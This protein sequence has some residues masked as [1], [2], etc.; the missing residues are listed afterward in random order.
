[1]ALV[2]APSGIAFDLETKMA[3]FMA[4][5]LADLQ[6]GLGNLKSAIGTGA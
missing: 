5:S 1:M 4:L 2:R 3:T 6:S